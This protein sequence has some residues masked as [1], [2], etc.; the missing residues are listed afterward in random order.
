MAGT[1]RALAVGVA[2]LTSAIPAAAQTTELDDRIA[3]SRV[4]F[5][6]AAGVLVAVGERIHAGSMTIT[7]HG[8][9]MALVEETTVD[10]YLLGIREVPFSWP[11]EALAAQV[12]AAR[13]YL[14]WTLERGR[15]PNGRAFNYDICA[16]TACQVY[17]GVGGL[18]GPDGARWIDAV[19]ATSGEVLMS[20]GFPVQALYSSTSDGR[21]RNVEDVFPGASPDPNLRAVESSGETSPFVAW[22]FTLTH[23]EATGMFTHAGLVDGALLDVTTR[24][25]ADGDG[26][27]TVSVA[28]SGGV[29]TVDTW[30]LRTW[31]N[32]AAA[33]LYPDSFPVL[34][35]ESERRYPQ[36]IMSP[37][38]VIESELYVARPAEGPPGLET[39]FRIRGGG[40]GHLVGMSQYGA[41]AMASAGSGYADILAHFYGGVRPTVADVV[42]GT[43][44]VGLGTEH[45]ELEIRP[46]GALRVTVDSDEISAGELGT[47]TVSWENGVALLDPPEGVGLPPRVEGWQTF[48]DSSGDVELVTVRS[49]TAAEVRVVVRESGIVVSD[50]GWEVRDAG[51][52]AVDL[53]RARRAAVVT[54]EVS[55]RSPLGADS[56][57]LRL[58][59]GAE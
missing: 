46:D 45:R 9:G 59:G 20:G 51:V 36:T 7:A 23:R 8:G 34:S 37:N 44:R 27:W 33:E 42:P 11:P 18:A 10:D 31:L 50:T 58:I 14:A 57:R 54:V 48:F 41:E 16:T 49:R 19:E 29:E 28:S 2:V 6:P 21:T 52:I 55:V 17:S 38:Y 35:P 15:A 13:T 53:D 25:T 1:L 43:I 5:E 4:E 22:E 56:T 39:R 47:W 12:V 30:T 26:P 32:R 40:W 24:R 3:A